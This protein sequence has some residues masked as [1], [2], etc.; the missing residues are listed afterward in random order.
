MKKPKFV[1]D[2]VFGVGFF[3]CFKWTREEIKAF[4]EKKYKYTPDPNPSTYGTLFEM[5]NEKNGMVHH[6]LWVDADKPE[7]IIMQGLAH[8]AV[9]LKNK[10]FLMAGVDLDL[11]NDETE[12]YYVSMIVRKALESAP[13]SK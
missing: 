5:H 7:H 4:M 11:K 8:E 3:I 9:H 12:A 2:E 1:F 6:I 13:C 10:I